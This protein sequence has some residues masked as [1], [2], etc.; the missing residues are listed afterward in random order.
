MAFTDN[1][2]KNDGAYFDLIGEK[3]KASVQEIITDFPDG[4]HITGCTVMKNKKKEEISAWTFAEDNSKF[5]FGGVVLTELA[6]SWI[7][8]NG[9][10]AEACSEALKKEQ[11]LMKLI[12]KDSA[13]G[14]HYTDYEIV[15]Q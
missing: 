5:F 8:D 2:N 6:K 11:P 15:E 3:E 4:V 14:N 10:T 13:N 9:G 7:Q 1:R 12:V